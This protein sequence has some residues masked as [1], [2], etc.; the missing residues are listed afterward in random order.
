MD[1]RMATPA[2]VEAIL[3]LIALARECLR[4]LGID[5]WQGPYPGRETILEDIGKGAGY[6]LERAGVAGYVAILPGEEPTYRQIEGAWLQQG[7][8]CTLHRVVADTQRRGQ[9]LGASLLAE[10]AALA[11][12][13]GVEALRV[14]THRANTPMRHLLEKQ[15]FVPCGQITL[16]DG[17]PRLAYEKR[18]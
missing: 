6:V 4:R 1:L 7:P 5:Q 10:A 2:D 14:D 17:A 16:A 13:R 11:Q 12:K 3:H 8:Y 9:G 15:G 18:L